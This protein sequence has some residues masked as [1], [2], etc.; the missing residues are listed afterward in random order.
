MEL[1]GKS[2]ASIDFKQ[3]AQELQGTVDPDIERNLRLAADAVGSIETAFRN[4][5]MAALSALGPILQSIKD[6]ELSAEGARQA[7]QILGALIAG[8]FAAST[9]V[10][11]AKIVKL[12]KDLG[13]AMRA[14]GAASAFLVGLTEPDGDSSSG[15]PATFSLTFSVSDVKAVQTSTATAGA[16]A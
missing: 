15:A 4:L 7:I 14:A 11:I 10:Q 3:L 6:F 2:A 8:A 16:A 12:V 5:Q 9:V 1:F 13:G